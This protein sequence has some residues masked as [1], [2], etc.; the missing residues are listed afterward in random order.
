MTQSGWSELYPWQIVRD[1]RAAVFRQ[2]YA[3]I[4]SAILAGTFASGA[5][6]PSTR[7]LA[8]RLSIARSSVVTAYEQLFAEGFLSGRVGSGTYV[9]SDLPEAMDV[10]RNRPGPFIK[11]RPAGGLARKWG[12]A[13]EFPTAKADRPFNTAR[14]RVDARTAEIW[15]K[16]TSRATRSLSDIHGAYSDPRG[17]AELRMAICDYVWVAR[18]VR[19]RAGANSCN[20]GDVASA[21]NMARSAWRSA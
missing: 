4:R 18:A 12:Q 2:V 13:V 5:K 20:R 14:M 6:L 1:G 17:L 9:S 16:L 15:R 7:A 10:V 8:K 19:C 21:R 3:Q 11:P